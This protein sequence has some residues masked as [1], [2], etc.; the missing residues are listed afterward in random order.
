MVNIKKSGSYIDGEDEDDGPATF[1]GLSGTPGTLEGKSLRPYHYRSCWHSHHSPLTLD[2]VALKM[3]WKRSPVV[4]Q[5]ARQG[6]VAGTGNS[7]PVPL[8]AEDIHI[9]T[10]LFIYF[11]SG[12]AQGTIVSWQNILF[13]SPNFL[14]FFL[15]TK[16]LILFCLSYH[17]RCSL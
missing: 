2:V 17:S 5:K 4:T 6:W 16:G 3:N 15:G 1:L 9:F 14:R 8:C 10:Y 12:T 7:V 11:W 13:I